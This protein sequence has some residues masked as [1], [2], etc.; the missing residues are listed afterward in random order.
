M[1]YKK[2]FSS[3]IEIEKAAVYGNEK[4]ESTKR[5]LSNKLEK[6]RKV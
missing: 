2:G 1:P 3:F 5:K 4:A 6:A